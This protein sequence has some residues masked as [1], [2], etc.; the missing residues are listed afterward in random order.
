MSPELKPLYCRR[1]ELTVE[2]SCLLWSTWMVVPRK[3]RRQGAKG[4]AWCS[5]NLAGVM[6]CGLYYWGVGWSWCSLSKCTISETNGLKWHQSA[7]SMQWEDCFLLPMAYWSNWLQ[8]G[9]QFTSEFGEFTCQN[10][11]KL[12]FTAPYHSSSNGAVEL[13]TFQQAM[14]AGERS[15]VFVQHW[16]QSFLLSY[17]STPQTTM[18][19]SPAE[20]FLKGILHT[21]YD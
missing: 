14:K 6:Y 1:S 21:Q 7:P 20:L 10:G 9:P 19:H 15:E 13:Q 4:V 2:G 5:K 16:L 18:G 3:L 8:K 17:Q 12:I 11:I